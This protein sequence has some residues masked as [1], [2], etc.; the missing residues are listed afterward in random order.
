MRVV[1]AGTPGFSVPCLTALIKADNI[2]VVGVVSQPDRK[3]GRGMKLTPSAVKQAALDAGID[4]ITPEK[5]RDNDEALLW[6]Q[7]KQADMLIVVA[8]GMILPVEWLHAVSIAPINVHASLLPRWRGAAPIERSLLA[9]DGETGV[10][11]MQMEEGLDTGGIYAQQN[12]PITSQTTGSELWF[13]LSPM[14]AQLLIE[15]LPKIAAGLQPQA[16]LAEGITYAKKITNE[17]RIIDWSKPA[18]EI[19]RL[20]RCFSPR[21][22][23]RSRYNGKWLKLIAG[24]TLPGQHKA[25]VGSV[26]SN[27]EG[28]D[29]AC[30]EGS[31]YRIK[32]LQPEGKKAMPA[33]DFLRGAQL[34]AGDLLA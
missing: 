2:D 33:T 21:P 18:A 30:A 9:G 13:N 7:E 16:Q 28:L 5:L 1:F 29:I 17:E 31:V 22:G 19:D 6:L 14:G 32:E 11:I 34:K 12:L 23:V 10:C 3:S 25:P 4:V 26:V 24:E 20:V 8:F 15:T 27:I